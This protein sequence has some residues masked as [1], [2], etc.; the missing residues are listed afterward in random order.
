MET[1]PFFSGGAGMSPDVRGRV[2]NGPVLG[3]LW[4]GLMPEPPPSDAG[5]Q[6]TCGA[7]SFR[8]HDLSTITCGG[9]I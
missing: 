7:S 1:R 8:V 2:F 6:Q 9:E 5:K 3:H 4:V